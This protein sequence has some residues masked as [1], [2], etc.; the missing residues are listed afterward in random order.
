[1]TPAQKVALARQKIQSELARTSGSDDG[2]GRA[3]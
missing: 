3:R 2:D 1:M